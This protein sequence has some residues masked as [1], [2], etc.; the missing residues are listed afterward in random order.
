[1]A[2]AWLGDVGIRVTDL[3]RSIAFY[4][5]LL[6]LEELARGS[7]GI[8]TSVLF[9]DRR[10]GQRLE[11]NHYGE[12]SPFWAPFVPGEG[13]DHLE[14]RVRDVP[15][16]VE[17]LRAHGVHPVNRE[18][19]VNRRATGALNVDPET[20]K[21]MQQEIWT[22]QSGHRVAYVRDPDGNHIALYDHPEENW[23][24]PVPDHY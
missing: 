21:M 24:D 19:W 9:R 18:L 3:A 20:A 8:D 22:T 4:T 10:S 16:M 1:M 11:L 15:Q 14:V 17:R 7:D 12:E 6:D 2:D 13:L 23:D 5:E